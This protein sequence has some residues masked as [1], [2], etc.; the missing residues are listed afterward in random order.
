VGVAIAEVG[1]GYD[2]HHDHYAHPKYKYSYGVD[3]KH[4][5]DHKSAYEYRDGGVTKGS[6]S[7]LQPDG[8][9]RTVNYVVDPKGGFQAEVL[10]K[11][12]AHHGKGDGH[13]YAHGHGHHG[14]YAHGHGHHGGYAHGHGHGYANV[15]FGNG[16]GYGYGNA[17]GF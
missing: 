16:L 12:H 5:G 1:H 7:L 17:G 6:Y 4:T 11:G 3:D 2:G 15:A 13:A 10:N 14:G 8:V 9:I